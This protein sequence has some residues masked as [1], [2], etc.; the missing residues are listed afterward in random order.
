MD[1]SIFHINFRSFEFQ[2]ISHHAQSVGHHSMRGHFIFIFHTN[3]ITLTAL[4]LPM[5]IYKLSHPNEF[6][7]VFN[8]F[9]NQS[10]EYP[11]ALMCY[12]LKFQ[13][14][15]STTAGLIFFSSFLTAPHVQFDRETF[16]SCFSVKKSIPFALNFS[17][18]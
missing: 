3:S 18:N 8:F 1:Q 5:I 10:V 11:A 14:I 9:A 12:E 17:K 4:A 2:R 13:L 16:F 15:T 6:L 7:T